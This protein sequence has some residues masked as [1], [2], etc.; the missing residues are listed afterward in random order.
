M[1][2]GN[3]LKNERHRVEVS[4]KYKKPTRF[5]DISAS[6]FIEMEAYTNFIEHNEIKLYHKG[7]HRVPFM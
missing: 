4:A 5:E 2:F 6:G 1:N 7:K 3:I